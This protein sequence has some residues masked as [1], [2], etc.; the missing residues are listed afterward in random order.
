MVSSKNRNHCPDKSGLSVQMAPEY[1][2]DGIEISLH[3]LLKFKEVGCMVGF[4]SHYYEISE[5]L[6]STGKCI[7]SLITG[8]SDDG[9]RTYQVYK[10]MSNGWAY[11]RDIALKCGMTYEQIIVELGGS[12]E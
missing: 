8:I 9:K 5:L 2:K 12:P 3:Y 7:E 1:A 11:A 10:D 4:V 6:N